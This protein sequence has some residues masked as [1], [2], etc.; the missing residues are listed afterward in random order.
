MITFLKRNKTFTILLFIT[1]LTALLGLLLPSIL[2][3]DTKEE[4]K[5]NIISLQEEIQNKNISS[6]KDKTIILK[7]LGTTSFI[8]LLGISIIGIPIICIIYILKVLLVTTELT[9]LL[10]NLKYINIIYIPIYLFPQIV[11]T[12]I[13]FLLMYYAINYSI[14]LIKHLFL[15]KEYSI[16]EITSRYLKVL[17]IS[18]FLSL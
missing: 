8:W 5:E 11:K 13:Y 18:I 12:I 6:K 14:F 15:K 3:E 17:V 2:K 1:A 16:Q 7:D 9:F 10:I 4:I